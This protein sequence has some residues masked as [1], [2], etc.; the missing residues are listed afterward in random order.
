VFA[1]TSQAIVVS[2]TSYNSTVDFGTSVDGVNLSGVVMITDSIG[3]CTGSLL[4]DDFTILTAGHCVTSA[5][6]QPIAT[7]ITV[8]FMGPEGPVYETVSSVTVDPSYTG[9]STAGGDLATLQLSS[10]APS[11]AVGYGLYTG[12]V[13]F[14]NTAAILLAGYGVSGNGTDGADGSFGTLNAGTNAYEEYGTS[15]NSAWSSTLLVGQ[16]YESGVSSTNALNIR[17]PYSASSEVDISHGDSGGPSFY[18]GE[19]IGVHDLGICFTDSS[20]NCDTPPSLNSSNN[21]YFGEL[22]AD[23]ST[24]A[25]ATWIEDQEVNLPEIPTS[26][27]MLL[28]LAALWPAFR[29]SRQANA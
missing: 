2:S 23:V 29:R 8:T 16:F 4:S 9:D 25:N 11:F 22:F 18:D 26:V 12:T 6:G 5:Y 7:N 20:G 19:I 28:G 17:H 3:G 21:S 15:L 13:S 14:G 10:Q 27:A 24:S 1:A